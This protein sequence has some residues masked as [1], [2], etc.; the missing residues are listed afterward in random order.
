M[1]PLNP[2][3]PPPLLDTTPLPGRLR[4]E[5]RVN[6]RQRDSRIKCQYTFHDELETELCTF[7]LTHT[8][9]PQTDGQFCAPNN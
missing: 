5:R 6:V 1:S 9:L 7:I 8:A 4:V 2:N 3:P